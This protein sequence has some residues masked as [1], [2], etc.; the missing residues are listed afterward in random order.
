MCVWARAAGRALQRVGLGREGFLG[1]RDPRVRRC[2]QPPGGTIDPDLTLGWKPGRTHPSPR[3]ALPRFGCSRAYLLQPFHAAGRWPVRSLTDPCARGDLARASS[4]ARLLGAVRLGPR[5]QK[6]RRTGLWRLH[7]SVTLQAAGRGQGL[8][9]EGERASR[10]LGRA[11]GGSGLALGSLRAGPGPGRA[12][13]KGCAARS[14]FPFAQPG[15]PARWGREAG[16]PRA[17]LVSEPLFS[18]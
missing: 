17:A 9:G 18:G 15:Q 3:P 11:P 4:S 7:P 13:R 1:L 5:G 6:G 10:A 16:K 12:G 8:E 14:G 2:G